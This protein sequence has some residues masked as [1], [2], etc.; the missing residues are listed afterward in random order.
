MGAQRVLRLSSTYIR[1]QRVFAFNLSLASGHGAIIA[2]DVD[3]RKD[4]VFF[5]RSC[6]FRRRKRDWF[7]V[8]RTPYSGAIEFGQQMRTSC[9]LF[10]FEFLVAQSFVRQQVF[11]RGILYHHKSSGAQVSIVTL[12]PPPPLLGVFCTTPKPNPILKAAPKN[13]LIDTRPPIIRQRHHC[14]F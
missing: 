9:C 13:S 14:L 1:T 3:C 10:K 5:S 12:F 2:R 11:Q 7:F 6:F 8:K 4:G